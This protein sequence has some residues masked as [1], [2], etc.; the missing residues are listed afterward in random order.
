MSKIQ[1]ALKRIRDARA[2]SEGGGKQP[3]RE[4]VE[5]R[6]SYAEV[7]ADPRDDTI[8]RLRTREEQDENTGTVHSRRIVEVDRQKL[9]QA[10]LLA[11]DMQ[12]RLL[13]DQY[14]LIK[15]PLLDN[16]VGKNVGLIED[17]N[18]IMVSSAL[19][20]DGKTFTCINLALSMSS[21]KDVR[22]LLVDADVPKPHISRIFGVADQPGLIDLLIDDNLRV[23]DVLLATDVP[24][25]TL[26][27]AGQHNDQSTE[28]LA[29]RRMRE[30]TSQLARRYSNRAVVFDSPPLLMTPESRVLA[31]HMGQIAMVVCAGRTPVQAA[32]DAVAC[33]DESKA[34]NLI[35]NQ[36]SVSGLSGGQYGYGYGYGYGRT[37]TAANE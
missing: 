21:E 37:E 36:S 13:A 35:L 10:G 34:L 31:S 11:P 22:V 12:A 32:Q 4:P 8:A 19:S 1:N 28:L 15:R 6:R 7:P 2:G 20:G 29:S 24:G 26:L 23:E 18:L 30:L 14:R 9:Q 25:L 16:A 33:I 5:S 17:G 27:P 3:P